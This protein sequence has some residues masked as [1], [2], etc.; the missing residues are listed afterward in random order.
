MNSPPKAARVDASACSAGEHRV[1]YHRVPAGWRREAILARHRALGGRFDLSG[2]DAT[3]PGAPA[4]LPERQDWLQYRETLRRVGDGVRAD[5]AACAELAVQFI[6]QRHI[7]SCSGFIRE[8]LARCLKSAR[9]DAAQIA[10]L[11]AH[12]LGLIAAGL[13]TQEHRDHLRLWGRLIDDDRVRTLVDQL[14]A[15]GLAEPVLRWLLGRM[16]PH[17]TAAGT[18]PGRRVRHWQD[19]IAPGAG[20]VQST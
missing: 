17:P 19:S 11:D 3:A 15:H 6:E 20:N 5:D 16:R 1:A 14:R 9:L 4:W 12:F 8:R 10:R 13:R 18:K 2:P 7:G